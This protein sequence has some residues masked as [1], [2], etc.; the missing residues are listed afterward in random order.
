MRHLILTFMAVCALALSAA[1]PG[2]M[3]YEQGMTYLNSC[4]YQEAL[5][6][7]GK[8]AKEGNTDA[9]YQIGLMFLDGLGVNK[10]PRDAAYWFRK[11]A[12]NGHMAS[13]FEIGY[14]FATGTGVQQDSRMA[15]EWYWRA[16]EQ[17]D[18]DAALYLAR[19]YRD[20]VGMTKNLEKARYYYKKASE[21]GLTEATAELEQ[22]PAPAIRKSNAKKTPSKKSRRK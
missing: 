2:E 13:Q 16:A 1:V 21:A 10:N 8:S 5:K 12:Q 7:F 6:Q 15:A 11:A 22:L 3:Q 20:G 14:C 18:P 9:Q 17:G 19:C 4:N